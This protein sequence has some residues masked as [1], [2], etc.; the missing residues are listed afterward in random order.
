MKKQEH[1]DVQ[2]QSEE[3]GIMKEILEYVKIILI[4][5]VSVYLITNFIVKPIRVD[6]ESMFPTL[7]DQ[8]AGLSNVLSVKLKDIN[9]FDVVIAYEPHTQKYW[10]KR[11]I[12]LPF[13][14]IEFKDDVLYING[15]ATAEP[16][17]DTEYVD[18]LKKQGLFTQN[19]GPITMGEDEY[20]LMGDNRVNS[21]DSRYRGPF[22][23]SDLVSKGVLVLFPLDEVGIVGNGSK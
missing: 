14:T 3:Q 2:N 4:S 21:S 20:F 5:L 10:V 1:N 18:E 6:G 19:F 15:E 23:Y 8:E 16:F 7:K 17:L 22:H 11:V 9:R 12:A 13:E